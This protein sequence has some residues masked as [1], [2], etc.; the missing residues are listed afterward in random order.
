[1]EDLEVTRSQ[2]PI[3]PGMP[4]SSGE[5]CC[6][7]LLCDASTVMTIQ[8]TEDEQKTIKDLKASGKEGETPHFYVYCMKPCSSVRVGKLRVR[9]SLCKQ[10]AITLH[11]DPCNWQDVLTPG[12]V[13]FMSRSADCQ[14]EL[15]DL[16]NKM[17]AHS[18]AAAAAVAVAMRDKSRF[19]LGT[20]RILFNTCLS[21]VSADATILRMGSCHIRPF[22][23]FLV[24]PKSLTRCHHLFQWIVLVYRLFGLPD[25]EDSPLDQHFRSDADTP[26]RRGLK[27]IR[28]WPHAKAYYFFGGGLGSLVA[29][30]QHLLHL[31][32][33]RLS[34]CDKCFTLLFCKVCM[35]KGPPN[36]CGP[37]VALMPSLTLRHGSSNKELTRAIVDRWKSL[38]NTIS[39]T[40][41]TI[42]QTDNICRVFTESDA[43]VISMI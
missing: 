38:G 23:F 42:S 8:L 1:M 39:V 20:K 14:S 2:P 25:L 22:K 40:R 7:R 6:A 28:N 36:R 11:R 5:N 29:K 35:H 19:D 27:K 10:G 37:P 13:D 43:D 12:Q 16:I 41:L 3:C 24:H 32:D 4:G 21:D 30:G 34:R 31:G 18:A 9:C 15:P 33:R 17:A 26:F